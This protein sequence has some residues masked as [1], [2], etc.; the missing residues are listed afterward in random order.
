MSNWQFW[1]PLAKSRA[2]LQLVRELEDRFVPCH[3]AAAAG[4]DYFSPDPDK[5]KAQLAAVTALMDDIEPHDASSPP[6]V[7][8]VSYSEA[9]HLADAAV[10]DESIKITRHAWS[11][12]G[13]CGQ[14]QHRRYDEPCGSPLAH[15][16]VCWR[17]REP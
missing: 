3:P 17:R 2:M 9:S 14:G 12:T 1:A 13:C 5:A 7:H 10:V 11:N 16:G 15:C 4:L 8:V 6:V